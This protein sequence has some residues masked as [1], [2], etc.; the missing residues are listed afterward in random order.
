MHGSDARRWRR[1]AARVVCAITN[2]LTDSVHDH[3]NDHAN[4][5]ADEHVGT[6]GVVEGRF[7]IVLRMY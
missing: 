7:R 5:H 1:I 6:V 4:E 2:M 3:V